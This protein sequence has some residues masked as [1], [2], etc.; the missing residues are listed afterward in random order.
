MA[1]DFQKY[2]WPT[3]SQYFVYLTKHSYRLYRVWSSRFVILM[4]LTNLRETISPVLF[5]NFFSCLK[6]YQNL[7][8][9]TMSSGAKILIL[10]SGVTCSFSVGNLRPMTSYSF[11]WK[12]KSIQLLNIGTYVHLFYDIHIKSLL[13]CIPQVN[14]RDITSIVSKIFI[15]SAVPKT[16]Q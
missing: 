9:A 5:L 4:K 16:N 6:K 12:F 13:Q 7:D 8:F 1:I 15:L 10:Y 3:I 11:N 14:R 2:I